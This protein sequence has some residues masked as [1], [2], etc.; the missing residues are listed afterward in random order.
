MPAA[1]AATKKPKEQQR[2]PDVIV[3][4]EIYCHHPKG[5]HAG[6]VKAHG[7]HG[8]TLDNGRKV[9]WEHVLG[10]KRRAGQ[11][12]SVVDQGEDGM[13]VEDKNGVRQFVAV[14][15]ES[16]TE[17]MV[18]KSHAGARMALLKAAPPS[19][20]GRPGLTQRQVTDKNGVQ[21]RRWVRTDA[22][23]PPAEPGHHVGWV[24]GEHKGH[25]QVTASGRDGVRAR[26]GAGGQHMVLHEHVTHHW[27]DAKTPPDHSPHTEDPDSPES[28][29]RALFNTSETDSLPAKTNQPVKNW[30]EL[31][32][33]STEGL[34]QYTDILNGI[35]GD[36]G[37]VTGKKPKSVE[38]AKAAASEEGK[39][40]SEDGYMMPQDWDSDSGYLFIGSLKGK[41]RA[42]EKVRTDYDGDWSQLRD[43]VRATIAVPSVTQIPKVL[44][45]LK[46]AGLE[47]AQKPK[48]NLVKPLP[49]GYRDL[50][51]VVKLPNGLL[52]EM[53]IH[54]K[55]MTL[56]KE[57]GH[58]PY[59][60]TRSIE[61]KYRERG[62]HDKDKWD[63][64]DK[65]AH[66]KAMAE[67][68][69]L[70]GDAWDKAT[71]K[72]TD[73]SLTKS[74]PEPIMLILRKGA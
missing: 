12:Y 69:K 68:E 13:I 26:D 24:N 46:A 45:Q 52:A 43:M 70:Y 62:I 56:A 38:L 33:K 41:E 3:G 36:L 10:H 48:N 65:D 73:G 72:K 20:P 6:K 37:M 60:T 63:A 66:G 18:V 35:A 8:V 61:G 19:A 44:Q 1:P 34:K 54:I 64:A 71:G 7:E 58:K 47:L 28:I 17:N 51:M 25:G 42:A 67:Q 31:K 50:N 23:A 57:K 27:A 55:P 15:P 32:Q 29:A 39:E 22:G 21:T 59:E 14:P 40:F 11:E 53:Q 74:L 5:P 4:D 9:R 30:A 2:K 16:R 49:G